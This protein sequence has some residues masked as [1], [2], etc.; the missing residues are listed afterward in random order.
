[1]GERHSRKPPTTV[2]VVVDLETSLFTREL[3]LTLLKVGEGRFTVWIN[4][5]HR[6]LATPNLF[7]IVGLSALSFVG[8]CMQKTSS[9][10]REGAMIKR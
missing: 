9:L 2:V 6:H 3:V 7:F 5:V 4:E 1:M 8:V 10:A